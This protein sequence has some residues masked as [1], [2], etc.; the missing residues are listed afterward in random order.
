MCDEVAKLEQPTR[1]RVK[2]RLVTEL[3]EDEDMVE[4]RD[5]FLFGEGKVPKP[6]D[7]LQQIEDWI[8]C[9]QKSKVRASQQ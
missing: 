8:E 4:A 6:E 1:K 7:S 5:R 2:L 3:Q 9:V